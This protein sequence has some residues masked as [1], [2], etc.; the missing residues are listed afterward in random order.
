MTRVQK[1]TSAANSLVKE[2]RRAVARGELTADG[3]LV[4]E[5]FHLLE[6]A[7]ASGCDIKLVLCSE[8]AR[9]RV[10]NSLR[11]RPDVRL[12]IL[13]DSLSS[14]VSATETSQGVITL[15]KPPAW[16]LD[17]V[18]RGRPLAVVLD[19]LQDPGNAGAIVRAGE[20]FGATGLV[21][22]KGC[23]SPYNPKAVRASAGSVLRL[24]VLHNLD[25]RVIREAASRRDLALYAAS[26]KGGT[27]AAEVDLRRDCVIVVG[28][29]G[30]GWRKDLWAGAQ[31]IRVPVAGVESLNAAM[32]AGILLYEARRQR[33]KRP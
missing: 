18:F 28:G 2:V 16:T 5:T 9:S 21:F 1:L 23:V 33:G 12:A 22:L 31:E 8:S 19:G 24:P 3:C 13:P 14:K 11:S 15:L 17:E 32:A 7:L 6:E 30:R 29:E 26:P 27:P 10:E 20:A 25:G 4:A